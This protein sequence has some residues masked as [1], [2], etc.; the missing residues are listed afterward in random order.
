MKAVF[1]RLY[2]VFAQAQFRDE[3]SDFLSYLRLWKFFQEKSQHLSGS[4]LRKLCK[5]TFLSYVRMREWHDVHN[6]LSELVGEMGLSA[7]RPERRRP[8]KR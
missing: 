8:G 4:Q 1:R 2:L 6:Q 5:N 7:R 3:S